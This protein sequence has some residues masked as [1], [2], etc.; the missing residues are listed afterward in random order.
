MNRL[1]VG[2]NVI[3]PESGVAFRRTGGEAEQPEMVFT[4]DL[5]IGHGER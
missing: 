1:E 3:P 4:G 5:I 2:W